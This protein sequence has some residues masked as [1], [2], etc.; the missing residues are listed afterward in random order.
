MASFKH[1]NE[2]S[3]FEWI[4]MPKFWIEHDLKIFTLANINN[5]TW[6]KIYNDEHKLMNMTQKHITTLLWYLDHHFI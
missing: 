1:W 6:L 4:K 2:A 3:S 5:G